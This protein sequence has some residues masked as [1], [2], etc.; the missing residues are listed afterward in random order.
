MFFTSCSEYQNVLKGDDSAAK[1]KMAESLYQVG[2]KGK[3][4]K[5]L[6]LMEQIVPLYRGKP[7]A[8]KLMYM[9]SN[10]FY[11]LEDYFVAGYQFERFESSY[12]KSDS[13]ERAAY[14]SAKSYY[15]L[16]PRFSLDQTD[17]RKA[18]E[19]LQAYVNKY[20]NSQFR[21]ESNALVKELREK[22]ERKDIETADQYLLIGKQIGSF[23]PAIDAYDNFVSDHP[24]SIYREHAF[25]GR[26]E[27]A[28]NRAINSIPSVVE[29]R[30]ITAKG[31][32][33]QYLKYYKEGEM[34]ADADELLATVEKLLSTYETTTTEN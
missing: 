25:Y 4:K 17:T 28:Y 6:R 29:E 2:T 30:L 19:K 14:K 1:L 7:Q 32:Y 16:S 27:A 3:Y 31:Y 15:E 23:K 10:T 34:K 13:V 9:Y 22:L 33:N 18:L 5:A 12:P 26:F 20:P 24:G 8:E 11:E 21:Q